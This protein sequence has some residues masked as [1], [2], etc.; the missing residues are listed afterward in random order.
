MENLLRYSRD[1]FIGLM[2]LSLFY[3]CT[4]DD[5]LD[6]NSPNY[7]PCLTIEKPSAKFGAGTIETIGVTGDYYNGFYKDSTIYFDQDTIPGYCLFYAYDLE[8]VDSFYWKVG[9]DPRVFT[10]SKFSLQFDKNL[11]GQSIDVRLIAL[12][13]SDCF[14]SGYARDTSTRTL[15]INSD[16]SKSKTQIRYNS[17]YLGTSNEFPG[18]EYLVEFMDKIETNRSKGFPRGT[19]GRNARFLKGYDEMYLAGQGDSIIWLA[20]GYFPKYNRK[21]LIIHYKI[22]YD[23]GKTAHWY[24]YVGYRQD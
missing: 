8:N 10:G 16:Y 5:P 20:H 2:I 19:F 15:V 1:I 17:K 4:K 18:E 14:P 22:S 23:L 7:N 6:P 3:A 21:E 24:T 9:T 13:K 11:H 12:K